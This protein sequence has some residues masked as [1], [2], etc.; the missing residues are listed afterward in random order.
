MGHGI[1]GYVTNNQRV[2]VLCAECITVVV[3]L[4]CHDNHGTYMHCSSLMTRHVP[5]YVDPWFMF[6]RS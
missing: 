1:H 3:V 6:F 4:H 5:T 2:N